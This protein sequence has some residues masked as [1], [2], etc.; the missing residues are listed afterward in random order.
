MP[1]AS[2]STARNPLVDVRTA[3]YSWGDWAAAMCPAPGAHRKARSHLPGS[4][5][6]PLLGLVLVGERYF[7]S[8]VGVI[9]RKYD[10][11]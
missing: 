2:T 4:G 9:T 3:F 6:L 1:G 7:T 11:Y 5:L 10:T 8:S